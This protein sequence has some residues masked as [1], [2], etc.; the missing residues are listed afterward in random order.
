MASNI[1]F[2]N[3]D[4][5]YKPPGYS[6]VVETTGPGRTVYLAGQLGID[7]NGQLVGAPGDF[8]AQAVQVMEN[9]K[10]A[11]ASVG[12]DFT[13]VVKVTNLLVDIGHL[14]IFRDVRTKYLPS[15]PPASTTIQISKLAREGA[16]LEV[17]AVA[18]LPA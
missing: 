11:L 10:D 2:L 5:L 15:P 17:E 13:N 4:T 14:P 12:A 8:H 16:L 6:H 9:L 1:R 7:K 3:P 18:V